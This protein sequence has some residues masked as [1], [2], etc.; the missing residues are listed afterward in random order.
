MANINLTDWLNSIEGLNFG[1]LG[2][3]QSDVAKDAILLSHKKGGQAF[4]VAAPQSPTVTDETPQ[5]YITH[6]LTKYAGGDHF[7]V[8][9]TRVTR[10][11][12]TASVMSAVELSRLKHDD[13]NSQKSLQRKDYV[14]QE[15]LEIGKS[16]N[17]F[18]DLDGL[19]TVILEKSRQLIGADAGSIYVVEGHDEPE[20]KRLLH[21]KLF[22]N[23]SIHCKTEE[24]KM[25]VS[26]ESI[27]GAATVMKR[28]INI[29][30]VRNFPKDAPY[31]FDPSWDERT[32]YRTISVCT[33]PMINQEGTV[34]GVIQLINRKKNPSRKLVAPAD[35]EKEVLPV[36]SAGMDLIE[37]LASQAGIAMEN[38]RLYA[39]IKRIFSGFVKASVHAIEQRDPTTSG[40]S[41]RVAAL[42]RELARV[43]S[44]QTSGKFQDVSFTADEIREIETAALL[45]DF[46]KV[47]VREEVLV[48]AKK[49][50][51]QNRE[52]I[53]SRIDF[54]RTSIE[55]DHLQRR[56]TMVEEGTPVEELAILDDARRRAV[57]DIDE[58][59]R[60][61]NAANE[62]TVLNEGDFAKV[63]EVAARTFFD[64]NGKKRHYLEAEEVKALLVAKGS[65]TAEELEEIRSHAAHTISFLERIPWGVAMRNI[66]KFAGCHHEKLDGSG[67]PNRLTDKD[68]PLPSKIMAVADIYD[69][70][71]AADRPYKKAV[72]IDKAF[73]ILDFEVKDNHIDEDLVSLFK[74]FEVYKVI[75][76]KTPSELIEQ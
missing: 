47:G 71:T 72:P 48:K 44:A 26:I 65:L 14:L 21:F 19:L 57:A 74:K 16:L 3:T 24:F 30:D 20:E 45:H 18:Q 43:V 66:P 61:I 15:L 53:R 40:H 7:A 51:P 63:E 42:T 31:K 35:F 9:D 62:P 4:I 33:V 28:T 36:D 25:P 58:C 55:N 2:L 17:S 22:Q 12:L 29:P 49:L 70:L 56:L 8:F 50:Y 34:M 68:I 23:D 6:D 60:I 64:V 13:L 27:A 32:G 52:V 41:F 37:T 1:E 67:Y 75:E 59:W 10:T 5:I 69:A 73:Q 76:G 38:A 11:Q 54:I 46:G 39:E